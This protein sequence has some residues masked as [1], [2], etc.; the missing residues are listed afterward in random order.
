MAGI[1]ISPQLR[2]SP[3]TA[4]RHSRPLPLC[5][6]GGLLFC[7]TAFDRPAPPT[8]SRPRSRSVAL[9]CVGFIALGV[10]PRPLTFSS[11]RRASC[12]P[13]SLKAGAG[14]VYDHL[15]GFAPT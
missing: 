15:L 8:R 3:E 5:D 9:C 4:K 14:S 2:E 1:T 12:G 10:S 6:G 7:P 13:S 11:P